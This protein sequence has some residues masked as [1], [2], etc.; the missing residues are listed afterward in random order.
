ML[1]LI[2]CVSSFLPSRLPSC[3]Y[4][5][6]V[7]PSVSRFAFLLASLFVV[8]FVFFFFTFSVYYLGIGV[9]IP[10]LIW[11]ILY[12]KLDMILI[13]LFF[14][15]SSTKS[16]LLTFG[17]YFIF[18]HSRIGWSHLQNKLNY[19]N[20][21]MFINALPFN[22]GA[23]ILFILFYNS[24]QL[25]LELG[26]VYSFIFLSAISFPHVICMHIFYKKIKKPS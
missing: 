7:F 3:F 20:T 25:N 26:I 21:K 4:F 23:I 15:F 13:I 10:F 24:L 8:L 1:V 2:C 14:V 22:I 19:S 11:A 12:K 6:F 9:L 5:M 16:L 18:Q 17:L